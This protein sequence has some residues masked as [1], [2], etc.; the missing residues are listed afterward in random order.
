MPKYIMNNI[1]V[2]VLKLD[3][4]FFTNLQSRSDWSFFNTGL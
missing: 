3:L 2:I 1:L 4:T